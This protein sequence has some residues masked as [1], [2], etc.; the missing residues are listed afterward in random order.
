MDIIKYECK[1]CHTQLKMKEVICPCCDTSESHPVTD[2][3]TNLENK[4]KKLEYDLQ[5]ANTLINELREEVLLLTPLDLFGCT[6]KET[7][8]E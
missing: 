3:I 8:L 2:I 4:I 1:Y 6:G 5:Y 7:F